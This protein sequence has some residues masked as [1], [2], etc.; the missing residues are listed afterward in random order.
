[1]NEKIVEQRSHR[2]VD[3]DLH[4]APQDLKVSRASN[5]N[6][7]GD[8]ERKT[9]EAAYLIPEVENFVE[10][11]EIKKI[12][13]RIKLWLESGYPGFRIPEAGSASKSRPGCGPPPA[14]MSG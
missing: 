8:L 7:E 2:R 1:M 3:T 14:E 9:V 12:V 11:S 6:Y 5:L 4:D 13:L 10:T